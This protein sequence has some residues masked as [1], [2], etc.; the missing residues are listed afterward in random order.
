MSAM[1]SMSTQSSHGK[2]G[3]LIPFPTTDRVTEKIRRIAQLSVQLS[4]LPAV[5]LVALD[6]APLE[7]MVGGAA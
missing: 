5:Q 1:R 4:R 6:L 7:R 2:P 3:E